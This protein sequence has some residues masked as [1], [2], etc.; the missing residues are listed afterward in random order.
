MPSST[1]KS[2]VRIHDP[3]YSKEI[4][5]DTV[6]KG[7][8]GDPFFVCLRVSHISVGVVQPPRAPSTDSRYTL[9][10]V[11]AY[12]TLTPVVESHVG[13]GITSFP[14]TEAIVEK[15]RKN[16]MFLDMLVEMICEQ[17]C[18]FTLW[19]IGVT[20]LHITFWLL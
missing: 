2:S 6:S 16:F 14:R 7:C 9:F 20:F 3:V 15:M 13:F 5:P 4:S 12:L 10:V 18:G 1:Y 11:D 19:L 17:V 8:R